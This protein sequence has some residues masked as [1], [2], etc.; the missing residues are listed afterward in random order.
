MIRVIVADDHPIVRSGIVGLLALD[1]GLDVVGEASDGAEAVALAARVRP[2]VVL[3]D[4]RMPGVSGIEAT[5]RIVAEHPA[6]RVLVLTTYETDD[7]ILGA[8]EAGASGYLLKAAPQEEIVAGIRA[9]AEGHTV[10]APAIAATLV[11]RMR[12]DR[13]ER[14]QLSPRELEVLRL[15]AAGRSNPEIARDLFIGE[16]TVKTHL[17]HVFEKL[18]VSD[19]TRA[20]T[21]ALELGLLSSRADRATRG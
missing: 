6:V 20:V 9:V 18:E 21:L 16:A 10:L 13:P 19:R 4:L 8:I 11:T 17:I 15:V 1:P 14:P 2:D 12:G 7:D 3:M 5:A